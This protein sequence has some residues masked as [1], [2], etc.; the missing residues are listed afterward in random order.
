MRW[1]IDLFMLFFPSNCLVCGKRLHDFGGVLCL[2]CE[3]KMPRTGYGDRS[4]N[5]VS[6]IFWGRVPVKNGTSLFMFEKGSAYQTLLHDLKYRGNIRVGKYLGRLLGQELKNTLFS[7]CDI[8][9]PVPLHPKRMNQRG[10]NQSEIIARGVSEVTGIPVDANL[11]QRTGYSRSQIS[12]NRQ[13]RF[14][15]ISSAF[16]LG[17]NPRDLNEKRILIIDDVITTGATLEAC[18]QVLFRHFNCQ[19]CIATVSCA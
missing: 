16:S 18:S 12:M 11:L 6:Q 3:M 19:I 5:P 13:E 8:L 17:R 7:E 15:N 4:D 10:Y 1:I 2:E 9:V 14:E